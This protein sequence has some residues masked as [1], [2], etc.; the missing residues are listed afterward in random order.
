[1]ID[2]SIL[3]CKDFLSEKSQTRCE[4]GT[5]SHGSLK[6]PGMRQPG[7]LEQGSSFFLSLIPKEMALRVKYLQNSCL[8]L[9]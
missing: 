3:F 2:I 9:M 1:M 5:E 4:A 6:H 7:S 8:D